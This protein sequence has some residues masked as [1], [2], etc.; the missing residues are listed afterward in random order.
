MMMM[1]SLLDILQD[2]GTAV[3]KFFKLNVLRLALETK[4]ANDLITEVSALVNSL[5]IILHTVCEAL[6]CRCVSFVI[7]SAEVP[8]IGSYALKTATKQI[9][10]LFDMVLIS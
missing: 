7:D 5:K 6:L 2:L 9:K 3:E 4:Q 10:F 8:L 1:I